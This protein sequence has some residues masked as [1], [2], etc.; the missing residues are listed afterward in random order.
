MTEAGAARKEILDKFLL[1]STM[2]DTI[3]YEDFEALFPAKI[4]GNGRI[5]AMWV[6]I[7]FRID[8]TPVHPPRTERERER[9]RERKEPSSC[10]K[11]SSPLLESMG[12][13]QR[14]PRH[15]ATWATR[16]S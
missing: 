13:V 14:K 5:R 1:A 8:I 2:Y 10:T 6:P 15:S 11:S 16:I 3:S 12:A 7:V 4:R 9:E